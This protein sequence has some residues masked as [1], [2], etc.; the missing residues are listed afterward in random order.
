MSDLTTVATA[1]LPLIKSTASAKFEATLQA[2]AEQTYRLFTTQDSYST[3]EGYVPTIM[4]GIGPAQEWVTERVLHSIADFGVR[5]TGKVYANGVTIKKEQLRTSPVKTAAKMGAAMANDAVGFPHRKAIEMLISNAAGFD[6]D[7]LFGNHKF[8]AAVGAAVYSN[9]IA[10]S[11]NAWYLLNEES[12]IEATGEA[13]ILQFYGGDNTKIDFLDDGLA[14]GWRSVKIFAPGFWGNSV[15]SKA[16]L[17]SANL[18]AAMNRQ[19]LF[20]NDKG[21]RIGLK[22]KFLVVGHSNA[23]AAEK[24]IKAALV[25]GGNTNLDMGRLQLIVL[26]DLEDEDFIAGGEAA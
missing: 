2:A 15:R 25:D 1:D 21:Q 24:L 11:N 18:R 4:G 9:D 22:P 7:P 23:A 14:M 17:T 13:A 19:A 16:D 8:S 26:D 6:R 3:T 20:K 12:L 5:F 10:G